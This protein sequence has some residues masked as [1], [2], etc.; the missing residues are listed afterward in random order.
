MLLM[1][2]SLLRQQFQSC[3]VHLTSMICEMESKWPY[4]CCFVGCYFQ[5]LF[6][7][8]H[9]I[10][11]ELL[12]GFFSRI[13]IRV[14]VVQPYRSTDTAIAWKNFHFTL[15]EIR[16]P[17]SVNKSPGFTY[18]LLSVDEILLPRYMSLSNF[19]N[20]PF[21]EEMATSWLKR[22]LFYQSSSKDLC[23]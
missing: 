17:K 15:S 6:K 22:T 1:C 11:V 16:F 21:N 3:L 19:R 14:Q 8:A 13:L 18:V 4:N 9:S 5:D 12:S 2:S 7:S 23:H 10:L 20:M